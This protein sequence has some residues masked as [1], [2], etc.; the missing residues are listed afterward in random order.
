MMDETC[1]D[2]EKL[3]EDLGIINR[4]D[5]AHMF[6]RLDEFSSHIQKSLD[7]FESNRPELFYKIDQVIISGMGASGLSGDIIQALY[8]D[9]VDLPIFVNKEYELPKW[10]RKNTLTIFLSYSGETEETISTF[11]QAYQKKCKI[12]CI[13]SGGKLEEMCKKREVPTLIIPKGFQPREALM[14]LLFPT[15]LFLKKTGV[16]KTVIDHDI[17]ESISIA[18]LVSDENNLSVSFNQNQAK[19]I[20][21]QLYKSIPQIYGWGIYTPIANRWRTQLN[22]NSKLVAHEHSIPECNHN[23]I[24]GWSSNPEVSKQFSAVLFRDKSEESLYL[25]ARLDFMKSLFADTVQ[26]TFEIHPRGKTRLA[27]MLYILLFGDYVSCYLAMLR[28]VDPSVIDA[29]VELKNRLDAL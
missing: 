11:K 21:S 22:E 18:Q 17:E 2:P 20:A 4:L 23:D 25:T 6:G 3:L 26:H 7:L 12:F 14:Y 5:T 13:T 16:V 10:S 19:K 24:V 1:V 15:I 9:K 29:I 8:R 27:K 28:G